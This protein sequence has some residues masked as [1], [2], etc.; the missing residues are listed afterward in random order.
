[1]LV[2][3]AMNNGFQSTLPA[4]GATRSEGGYAARYHISIHAPRTGSDSFRIALLNHVVISIHA[5]RTGSDDGRCTGCPCR[6]YFNP[7]SPH[8]ERR[9]G[10]GKS[11]G[12]HRDFNPRSPH[13]ERYGLIW[14][15]GEAG[16]FQSTLPARGATQM[17]MANGF[18]QAISIHA[19][20]TGSDTKRLEALE[21]RKKFQS[22]LPARGATVLPH[23]AAQSCGHFNPRSPH[24]ER[25]QRFER[26]L[27]G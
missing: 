12:D 23:C 26:S 17:Q 5:P 13:G 6:R 11:R 8:G 10:G 22:T 18:A 25:R 27:D 16:A 21:G 2:A 4:R 9:G 24:G 14:V 1:M 20:R 19:P 3:H 7:R 15:Q